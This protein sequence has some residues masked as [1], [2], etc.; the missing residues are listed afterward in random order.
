MQ[1]VILQLK[2][3]SSDGILVLKGHYSIFLIYQINA[4]T[5]PPLKRKNDFAETGFE[6][7]L[8]FMQR[9]GAQ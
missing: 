3:L 4:V 8:K 9:R 5:F 7:I 1:I 2:I 6:I